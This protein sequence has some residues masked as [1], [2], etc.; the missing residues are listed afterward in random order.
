[1]NNI[2]IGMNVATE[3]FEPSSRFPRGLKTLKSFAKDNAKDYL[4]NLA[5]KSCSGE[6]IRRTL[7]MKIMCG[8]RV[9]VE[10]VEMMDSSESSSAPVQG[11][12]VDPI[13][14][15]EVAFW[16][17]WK[18][19]ARMSLV[20]AYTGIKHY[21]I[22]I[23]DHAPIEVNL[24]LIRNEGKR[25]YK[26]DAWA[27]D[28]EDCLQEVRSAWVQQDVGSPSFQVARK[29][30]RVRSNV[31]KWSVDKRGEWNAKWEDFDKILEEGMNMAID[32]EEDD[33]Y[34]KVNDEV[35]EFSKA[36]AVFWKQRTKVQWMV[37]GDTCTKFYFNWGKGRARRIFI[38][39]IKG[40]DGDWIYDPTRVNNEFQGPDGIPAYVFHKCWFFIKKDFTAAVLST[41]NSGRILRELNRTFIALILK[42]DNPEGISDYRPISLC[43][44]FMR[45]VSKCIINR[46]SNVMGTL[47]SDSQNA[48]LPG[49]HIS[50][51]IL[52]AHEAIHYITNKNIGKHGKCA[53][54]ADMSKAYDRIRWDFLEAVLVKFGFPENIVTLIMNCVTMVNYGVLFNGSPLPQFK[55]Q[56]G[57]RQGDPL[58]PFL[59]ILCMEVL[60]GSIENVVELGRIKGIELCRGIR[61]LSHVFF[62]DDSIFFFHDKDDSAFHLKSNIDSYCEASGQMLNLEK[63]GILFS[64][65]TTLAKAQRIMGICGVRNGK[66]IGKYLGIPVEFQASKHG[67]FRSLLEY[68]TRRI[69]SSNGIFLSPAGSQNSNLKVVTNVSKV[70][71]KDEEAPA[72]GVDDMTKLADFHE[73]GVLS[74]LAIRYSINEI[75][76]Y[77]GSIFIAVNPFQRL[78]NLY[79]IHMMDQ[80]KGAQFG[81][82]SPHV[83]AIAYT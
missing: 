52:L 34:G 43:N 81:E 28:Y 73:P 12:V 82:L 55:P 65:S 50:D 67:I 48:F 32:G 56:C 36:A 9:S 17:G 39:G 42:T 74:N 35:R 26:L 5:K 54:K 29:L 13:G 83:F 25:P 78:P 15:A 20:M 22:Q 24:Q 77:T 61:P 60:A 71:P 57:L 79:D 51:N 41:L 58:S 10:D 44:V 19:E 18:K 30:A 63:S 49:R 75:Y 2:V 33:F 80:Y 38:H 21:P 72:G 37:E 3:I 69:S 1:M 47:A 4:R 14:F 46:I 76:T 11:N 45:I 59:F 23:S 7:T 70:Y 8:F 31:K 66:G 62:V 27:L 53:F 68:V 16:V 6:G 40:D 64:P